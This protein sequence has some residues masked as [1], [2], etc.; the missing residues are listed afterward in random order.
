MG[1]KNKY[2]VGTGPKVFSFKKNWSDFVVAE[3]ENRAIL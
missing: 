1:I 2:E 3:M